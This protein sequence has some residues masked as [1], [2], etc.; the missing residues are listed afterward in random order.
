MGMA[1]RP[2]RAATAPSRTRANPE[3]P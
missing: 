3:D 2:A 1:R